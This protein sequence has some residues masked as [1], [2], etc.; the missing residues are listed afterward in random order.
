MRY[1]ASYLAA[2]F[3]FWGLMGAVLLLLTVAFETNVLADYLSYVAFV[4]AFAGPIGVY[5][6][7]RNL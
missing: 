5:I 2:L 1:L 7:E 6:K 4:G 3:I